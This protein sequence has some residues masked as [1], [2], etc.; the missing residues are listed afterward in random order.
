MIYTLLKTFP[1]TININIYL[2]IFFI[3]LRD[4]DETNKIGN[5]SNLN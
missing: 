4:H 1:V 3:L 5:L 2:T